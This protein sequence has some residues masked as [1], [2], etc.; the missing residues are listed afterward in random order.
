MLSLGI[1]ISAYVVLGYSVHYLR[2][3]SGIKVLVVTMAIS[4]LSA[5]H[6]HVT[7]IDVT[8][9]LFAIDVRTL[10]LN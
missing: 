4:T 7:Q 9:D 6:V 1:S 5:L 2:V 10:G 8:T 3:C